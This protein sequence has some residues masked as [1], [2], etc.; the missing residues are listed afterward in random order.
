MRLTLFLATIA[1]AAFLAAGTAS[2]TL[3]PQAI[4]HGNCGL[5]HAVIHAA[6]AP[7]FVDAELGEECEKEHGPP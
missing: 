4:E 1:G 7:P 3:P 2:A 5:Q 6:G